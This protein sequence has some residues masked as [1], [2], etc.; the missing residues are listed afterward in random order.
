M[1][2]AKDSLK[3][4]NDNPDSSKKDI[5]EKLNKMNEICDPILQRAEPKKKI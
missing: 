3:F 1:E 5:D 4:L 2:A